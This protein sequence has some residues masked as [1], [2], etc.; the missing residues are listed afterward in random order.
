M[1]S[2]L[3][4]SRRWSCRLGIIALLMVLVAT[5]GF[6][7]LQTPIGRDWFARI[8]IGAISGPGSS[9]SIEGLDGLLP[10][11]MTATRIA[12]SDDRGVS[13][14]LRNV[15]FDLSPGALVAGRVRVRTLTAATLDVARWPTASPDTA[16]PLPLSERLR[17]P[18]L[19]VPVAIDR[20][21]VD[22]LTL[23]AA[24]IRD[25]VEASL[26]G[27]AS[28]DGQ[29]MQAALDLDRIDGNPGSL[30]LRFGLSGNPA[31]LTL[32]LTAEE[33]TGALFDHVL[34]RDGERLPLS[35]SLTGDAPLAAWRAC[36][37]RR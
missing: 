17:L 31:A 15:A 19:P 9:V 25:P 6:G 11:H 8:A 27:Y 34:H 33:P 37:V 18:R 22:R 14:A 35:L 12:I 10:F 26:D 36:P 4:S 7:L 2:L 16:P 28:L 5:G 13:L 30:A 1:H 20:L 29:S 32:R 24:I 23:N 21:A 3:A